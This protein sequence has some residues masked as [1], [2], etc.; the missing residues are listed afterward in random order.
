MRTTGFV[1][2]VLKP[3]LNAI[4]MDKSIGKKCKS[5]FSLLKPRIVDLEKH[6]INLKGQINKKVDNSVFDDMIN[7]SKNKLE[8]F[9]SNLSCLRS[10]SCNLQLKYPNP[11]TGD[12]VISNDSPSYDPEIPNLSISSQ[13]SKSVN[14]HFERANNIIVFN[15]KEHVNETEDDKFYLK[16]LCFLSLV[17]VQLLNAQDWVTKNNQLTDLLRLNFIIY[18]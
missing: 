15:L 8:A 7:E 9:E 2:I 17:I 12:D 1:Q 14:D 6:S 16:V 5:Y 13:V 18:Q 4:F 11:M 10:E 3:A